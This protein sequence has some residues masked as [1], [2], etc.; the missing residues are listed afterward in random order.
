MLPLVLTACLILPLGACAPQVRAGRGEAASRCDLRLQLPNKPLQWQCIKRAGQGTKSID[1]EECIQLD[2][3]YFRF[4]TRRRWQWQSIFLFESFLSSITCVMCS[5][6]M[7]HFSHFFFLGRVLA[8]FSSRI[9]LWE[10][11]ISFMHL[12]GKMLS[13]TRFEK[14]RTSQMW[15]ISSLQLH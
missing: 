13:G 9:V 4:L 1:S 6:E 2:F 5:S 11:H 10:V 12:E 7:H 14:C 8:Y 15:Q 3:I